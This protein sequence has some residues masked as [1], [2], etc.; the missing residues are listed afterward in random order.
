MT[1]VKVL[2][3]DCVKRNQETHQK[4][5]K[6]IPKFLFRVSVGTLIYFAC[7]EYFGFYA[8]IFVDLMTYYELIRNVN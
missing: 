3:T 7:K 8:V 4:L 6:L 2:L 5:E 1:L